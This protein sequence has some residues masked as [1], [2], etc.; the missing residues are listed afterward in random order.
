MKVRRPRFRARRR[1]RLP[2]FLTRLKHH[3]TPV[4]RT[5]AGG[6]LAGIGAYGAIRLGG[7]LVRPLAE[8]ATMHRYA[9]NVA[10]GIRNFISPTSAVEWGLGT[11]AIDTIGHL[12]TQAEGSLGRRYHSWFHRP[13]RRR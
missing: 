6:A 12:K 9:P 4:E 2:S 7:R 8:S 11:T 3:V 10:R 1:R 5:L 13:R